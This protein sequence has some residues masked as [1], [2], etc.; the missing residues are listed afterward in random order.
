MLTKGMNTKAG[1]KKQESA[2]LQKGSTIEATAVTL[3]EEGLG[4]VEMEGKPLF[5]G[6]ILPGERAI[7]RITH[8]GRRESFAEVRTLLSRSKA[9]VPKPP[10]GNRHC[11]GCPLIAMQYEAQLAWKK[12]LV[13]NEISRYAALSDVVLR[14]VIPSPRQLGYRNSAKLVLAGKHADPLIGIYRRN[15][16]DVVDISRCPLHHP[17]I[18]K[19]VGAAREGII[20]G[21][22]PIYNPKTGSGL[23]R[24]LIVRVSESSGKAMVVFITAHRS[25]NE[26][27]HLSAHIR[28]AIP[29]ITV[30]AQNVNSSEGNVILGQR[31][32]FLTKDHYLA[33]TLGETRFAISPRSFFQVNNGSARIIYEKV[34]EW[35]KFSGKETAIDLY[36]G[37]G[38]ISL[39]LAKQ[40]RKLIGIEVVDAAVA[41]AE[42]NAALN[43]IDNCEFIAGDAGELLSELLEERVKPDL[44]VLN[45]PRKGCEED[46]LHQAANL[47]PARIIYV[48]C[49]PSS[50]ARDLDILARK[51]Y[52]TL[53]IQPVDMFP[54]TP[55]IENVAFI[56]K[57]Q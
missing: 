34:R 42:R 40:A 32:F 46:V 24:Y 44:M 50:L 13:R 36:C 56:E 5:A 12:E 45:P 30:V 54:Q 25:F 28:R 10:C 37:I 4:R 22:V 20:R 29:D 9:R 38:G 11:D 43:S 3:T 14:D 33:D 23:L 8:V 27:H 18:N 6:G 48:S 55:H 35:A 53:E 26:I 19:V 51:G 7:F 49:S 39:F 21:K 17:L 47:K 16:H 15:S 31:D 1:K 2:P 57:R 41:D 52:R